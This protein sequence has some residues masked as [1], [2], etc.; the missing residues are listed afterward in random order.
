[1]VIAGGPIGRDPAQ[2]LA[3]QELAKATYHPG[4]SFLSW[5]NSELSKLFNGASAAIPGGWWAVVALGALVV[6]LI[7]LVLGR[8]GPLGR[9]GRAATAG[10]LAGPSP[11][12]AQQHRDLARQLAADGDCSG[13][14]LEYGRAIAAELTERA[15]LAPRPGRTADEL[16]AEA[17]LLLPGRAAELTAAARLFD[18]VCYGGRVGTAD[19]AARL[20]A[21]DDAIRAARTST[22]PVPVPS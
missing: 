21:L 19:G 15:L 5:L 20:R 17:A 4:E 11:L 18:D 2:L 13:A 16:A 3:R 12:T 8:I 9:S 14:I 22:V 7:A 1:M 10:P 6:I